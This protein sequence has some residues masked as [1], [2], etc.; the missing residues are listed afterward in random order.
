MGPWE[1]ALTVAAHFD[2]PFRVDGV[3]GILAEADG[4]F[5]ASDRVRLDQT[6]N[7][8]QMQITPRSGALWKRISQSQC[9]QRWLV[10]FKS[11]QVDFL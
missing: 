2:T 9:L 1:R 4:I 6:G 5:I 7:G 3:P 11:E 10:T 8:C